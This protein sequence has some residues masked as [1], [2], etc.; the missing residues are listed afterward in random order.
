MTYV[1]HQKLSRVKTCNFILVIHAQNSP[2]LF[3]VT[4]LQQLVFR[5]SAS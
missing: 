3:S 5:A 1:V 4:Y 2:T